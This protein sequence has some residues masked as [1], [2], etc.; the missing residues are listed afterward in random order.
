VFESKLHLGSVKRDW[1]RA[2]LFLALAAA[3]AALTSCGSSTSSGGTSPTITVS[4]VPT[5]VFLLSTSQCT[6]NV[7]NL[8]STLVNWS[9]AV[10]NGGSGNAGSI[11]SG[12]LYTAPSQFPDATHNAVTITAT[13]QVQST[14]TATQGLTLE[15]P[16]AINAVT[17]D[18]PS[19]NPPVPSSV[20][21]SGNQLACTATA[22]NGDKVAV[23]WSVANTTASL[24]GNVGSIIAQG[25]YTAP[26]VPPP[27]ASVTITATPQAPGTPPMT[28]TATVEYGDSV[29][30]GA[31]VFSATGRLGNGAFW[32]RAGSFSVG[33]GALTGSEDT[34]QGGTPNSVI[35]RRTFTGSYSVGPDGRGTMQFCENA[36]SA[37]PRG[38]GAATAFFRIV[39]ASPNQVQ[40]IEFSPPGATSA[41]IT[42]SGEMV[43]Q[44][45]QIPLNSQQLLSGTYSFGFS[46]VS[47][48]AAEE[49]VVGEFAATG[50]GTITAGGAN[51][52]GEMDI[53]P[54]L[55]GSPTVLPSTMYVINFPRGTVNLGGLNFAF[56]PISASR[57]KFIEIDP[58]APSTATSSILVGD[59]YEQQTSA[60]CAWTASAL[61][62]ATVLE[63][64]GAASGVKVADVGSFTAS[65]TGA[66]GTVSAGSL[67]QNSGGTVSSAVGTLSGSYAMDPCGRGTLSIGSHSYVYYIISPSSAV[68]QETTAGTVAHGL[69]APSQGGPL[70]D[71]T[72]TGSYALQMSGTDAA[73]SAGNREDLLGQFTSGGTGTKLAG[74]LDLNDFGTTQQ[75]LAIANGMYSS[76]PASSL[77]ATMALP[78]ATSPATTR[79]LVL[80]MVSPTL[81][82]A[83]DVDASPAGT[84]VGVISNQF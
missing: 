5:D 15:K 22:S 58:V 46:G 28:A 21:S 75:D 52:P 66:V 48:A 83:L 57:A 17:C 77:R 24:G 2:T 73:G 53:N 68:L 61:T 50:F 80:Y 3:L 42:A 71:A 31:Y 62:G 44:T 33:G 56:Y 55:S 25:I 29:L 4:C 8:S 38:S 59:A 19:T 11:T 23:N 47:S 26:L 20:V 35:Q 16:I 81:F 54:P 34:N 7:Q 14:L 18:D 30:S 9:V 60:N 41:T 64:S 36:A 65:N 63:T 39:V 82:Y 43:S 70:T 76:A 84:A 72:L 79:N 13:S 51:A 32:A 40:M 37:C 6:A 10:S 78:V 74:T 45:S 1:G 49:S 27:G 12:G 67:D 69:L